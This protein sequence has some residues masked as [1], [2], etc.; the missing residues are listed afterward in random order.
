MSEGCSTSYF[1]CVYYHKVAIQG[2]Q[3]AGHK[4]LY[5]TGKFLQAS[6]AQVACKFE[7]LNVQ[8]TFG[9]S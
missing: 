6:M 4:A 7:K 3:T 8:K 2:Q 1:V 9:S 5:K